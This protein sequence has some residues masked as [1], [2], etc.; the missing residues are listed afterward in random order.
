MIARLLDSYPIAPEVRHFIFEVPGVETLPYQ[1][2]QFVSLTHEING[3]RITRA[4]STASP[5]FGNRFELCLN[6][7]ADGFFSPFLFN[8]QPGDGVEMKGPLGTFVWRNPVNDSV[9]VATG[10]GIAPFRGML[11]DLLPRDPHHRFV[12]VLGAR[13]EHG[14]LY[15]DEF[16]E[17]AR[18]H[19][20]FEPIFT[21][22]RPGP[23][24][25]GRTGYVQPIVREVVG[26]RR[27]WD[28]YTC[29]M[30]AMVDSLRQ[31]LLDL[32]FARRQVI[33]EKYD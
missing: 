18:R 25:T 17:M 23:A 5:A 6:R 3:K 2:G 13:Y 29:G 30:R 11:H 7:V 31:E 22:S 10:T 12:L 28:V 1:P 20:N 14:L 27:D 16:E 21:L 24:W 32:G 8:L 15:R 4:Y 33:V 26:E 19:P 9:L